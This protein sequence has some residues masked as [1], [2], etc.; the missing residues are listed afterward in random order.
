MKFGK[1]DRYEF[2]PKVDRL[3]E[4]PHSEVFRARDL[5]LERDVA[6]KVLRPN[7]EIDPAAV[8][9]F[10]REAKN[11]GMLT[12]PNVGM[13][14]DFATLRG[15]EFGH[16][17]GA[18]YI[19]MEYLN[20][21]SLSQV[22]QQRPLSYEEGLRVAEQLTDALAAVHLA[23]LIHRDLKPANVMLLE[24]GTAKLLDFGISRVKGELSLTQDGVLVGTVLYMSPE[25]VRGA[26][27]GGRS[28]LF[29]LGAVLYHALT[30]SLPFPGRTFP[31]VCMAILDGRPTPPTQVRSG[32]PPA[33]ENFLL[34]CMSPDVEDRFPSASAAHGALLE[35]RN[36]MRLVGRSAPPEALQGRLFL[37][38]LTVTKKPISEGGDAPASGYDPAKG[39]ARGLIR[40]L[41]ANLTRSTKLEVVRLRA[42]D[43]AMS[44]TLSTKGF[45]APREGD[46]MVRGALTMDGHDATLD[47]EVGRRQPDRPGA[48]K[49][50]EVGFRDPNGGSWTNLWNEQLD[51]QDENDFGLQ[52]HLS[53]ALARTMRRRLAELTK[54]ASPSKQRETA[55]ARA[56][57]LRSH[58]ILH[59][60]TSR[61]L[62]RAISG[63]RKAL[64]L[65]P[66]C[67]IAH[68]G[69]AEALVYKYLMWD[70]NNSFLTDAQDEANRA[71]D[72][73]PNCSEAHTSL[74]FAYS[75]LGR[76]ADARR[77]WRLAIQLDHNEWL[78]YR[79]LG[80]RYA[81][82]G[83]FAE[84]IALLNKVI[85]LKPD[86]LAA[87]DHLYSALD[88]ADRYTDALVIADKGVQRAKVRLEQ[89]PDDQ[90]VRL[91]LA[92]LLARRG[93][94]QDAKEEAAR[95]KAMFPKDGYTLF[96]L[97][98]VFSLCDELDAA[99][100]LLKE[101][102]SRGYYIQSE[103][104]SN[105]D[106]DPLRGNSEFQ[107]L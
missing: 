6:L 11:T 23:G 47:Y 66:T 53:D 96:H 91:H 17:D 44:A 68:A 81:R 46:L 107:E 30:Q 89:V 87:Y 15:E 62:L 13:V 63:F 76:G 67:A 34:R 71:L 22:L 31:E 51:H 83:N 85:D 36:S 60:S 75:M 72:L 29:S 77:E 105:S 59:K 103:L 45:S 90:D 1:D 50:S 38:P 33:L 43:F 27:L 7:A 26:E 35:V 40:D 97:A 54:T 102:Q 16:F 64:D 9:R 48:N 12:H 94:K 28:D 25:Q 82:R 98:C 18:S 61:Q 20:G 3:G 86:H 10:T 101:A 80:A 19:A 70:G 49:P 104:H 2:D 57:T 42:S 14:Y 4:S 52:L 58:E 56:I 79:L 99:L 5:Q 39:I 84:A 41:E 78:A 55:Q 8:E 88:K 93:S 37:L 24:D 106:L 100:G 92:L 65:D 73:D 32:F 74:G 95:A 69:L 21:R